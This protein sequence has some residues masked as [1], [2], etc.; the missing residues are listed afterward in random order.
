MRGTGTRGGF[1]SASL[2]RFLAG[3]AQGSV[4]GR[5]EWSSMGLEMCVFL[6]IVTHDS[7]M[8]ES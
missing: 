2:W 1:N 4:M 7:R 3:V 5:A 6:Y 8:D